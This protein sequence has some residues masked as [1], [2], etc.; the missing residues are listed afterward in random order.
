MQDSE[1][2][3]HPFSEAAR[4]Y[5]KH[6]SAD[7]SEFR[8]G[9]LDAQAKAER[10]KAKNKRAQKKFRMKQKEKH[11]ELERSAAELST[12]LNDTLAEL[13]ALQSQKRVLEIALS[14]TSEPQASSSTDAE[15]RLMQKDHHR[16][17][18]CILSIIILLDP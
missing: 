10:T 4:A 2:N 11:E 6:D 15:A 16:A 7:S 17:S 8:S 1:S 13:D 14:R 3:P 18:C 9:E 5:S 12:K